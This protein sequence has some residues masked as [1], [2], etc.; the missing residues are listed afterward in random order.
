M[1]AIRLGGRGMDCNQF[2]LKDP[3]S[4]AYDM[5]DA[6][7]G[8][9]FDRVLQQ[10]AAATDPH[11]VRTIAITHEHLDHV[12]GIPQWQQ[13]GAKIAASPACADKLLAGHD[14]TSAM[15]GNDI[16]KLE[17]DQVVHD[18]DELQLGDR[19]HKVLLT[20]GHSPGSCC[21]W[22]DAT[23]SLFSGDTVFAQGGIGRFDFPDGDV[24][25]LAQSILRLE[26]LPVRHLHCGHGPSV[27][28]DGAARS[29]QR[30]LRHVQLC[31][32]EA[33]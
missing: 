11:R 13:L 25:V 30:S 16:P 15:F 21:Y 4:N 23:G 5:V 8:I 33:R 3:K 29:M 14:P 7:L 20:P 19:S 22:D 27:E 9:D 24:N 31:V 26:A 10:V 2:L 1:T 12:N 28:G 17:V 6:G 18:G 32:D